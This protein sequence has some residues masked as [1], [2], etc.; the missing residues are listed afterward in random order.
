MD[1][2]AITIKADGILNRIITPVTVQQA[3]NY[4]I[5]NGFEIKPV[6]ARAMW[7]TGSTGCCISQ[8]LAQYLALTRIDSWNL[9]SVHD[10]KASNVYLLDIVLPDKISIANVPAVEIEAIGQYDIIIG[11]NIITL[12][13]LAIT[14]DSGKTVMSFRLPAANVPID[15]SNEE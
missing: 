2:L 9:T 12:G 13:D 11:M 15:F 4:C 10:S 8:R 3:E 5:S 6:E 7:D 1:S 14:N